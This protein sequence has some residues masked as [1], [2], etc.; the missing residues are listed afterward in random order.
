MSLFSRLCLP[1][2]VAIIYYSAVAHSRFGHYFIWTRSQ[3]SQGCQNIRIFFVQIKPLSFCARIAPKKQKLWK[4][5]KI[6]KKVKKPC[7]LRVFQI[8]FNLRAILAQ[9]L[10]SFICKKNSDSLTPLGPLGARL[11]RFEKIGPDQKSADLE[12]RSSLT[13]LRKETQ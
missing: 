7:F 12:A 3:G 4:I 10:N 8:F 11:Y 2:Y 13:H 9:K 6:E 1:F 5:F